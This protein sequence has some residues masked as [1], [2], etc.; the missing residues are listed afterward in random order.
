MSIKKKLKTSLPAER[1]G[2]GLQAFISQMDEIQTALNDGYTVKDIWQILHEEGRMPIQ[3]R[4]FT[5][6]V[7]RYLKETV[8]TD[9]QAITG[10]ENAKK[11]GDEKT[12][13]KNTTKPKKFNFDP[14]PLPKDDLI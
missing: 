7:N 10:E 1:K 9:S 12:D 13:R 11:E 3:Y 4:A 14:T 8:T 2:R 5:S 6:Y